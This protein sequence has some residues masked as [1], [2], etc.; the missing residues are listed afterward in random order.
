M[1]GWK[2]PKAKNQSITTVRGKS[3][4][5]EEPKFGRSIMRS[6]QSYLGHTSREYPLPLN[7][8][9]NPEQIRTSID[10]TSPTRPCTLDGP[11]KL[12]KFGV[13]TCSEMSHCH[14]N[15]QHTMGIQSGFSS[16]VPISPLAECVYG[17]ACR[18]VVT[19]ADAMTT[20]M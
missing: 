16:A 15:R 9:Y 13:V 2:G 18:E 12:H 20:A 7:T 5:K 1:P 4:P 6:C 14:Q 19:T 3:R 8:Q 17:V 10:S 11:R